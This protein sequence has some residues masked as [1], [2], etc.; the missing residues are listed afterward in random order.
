MWG[1]GNAKGRRTV[2]GASKAPEAAS[3]TLDGQVAY[4][5]SKTFNPVSTR[6]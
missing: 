2:R 6:R 4:G 5:K 1:E 3:A